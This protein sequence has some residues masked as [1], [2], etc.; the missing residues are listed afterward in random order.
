VVIKR[1][2]DI[3]SSAL[4][5]LLLSPLLLSLAA[6]IK[7]GSAGSVFYRGQRVG[8]HGRPFRIFKFRSMVV[9]AEAIG[10][11]STGDHDPR[12]TSIG[13]F[14]R[15]GKL[16]ELPQ[17]L[18]V[19]LGQM[20]LVGPRPEVQRYVDLYT[21]EERAILEVRPGITD[22]ASIWN[23][24]EGAI[25][26]GS[27][28]PDKAY[29]ELIR[30]T[31]LK[32][33]LFYVRQHSLWIDLKIIAYTLFK[34]FNREF[35][36][37][38]IRQVTVALATPRLAAGKLVHEAEPSFATVTELPGH[39]AT[40]EQLSMIHTRYRLAAELAKDKDVLELACGP[41]IALGYLQTVARRVV[42]GD[43]D[44][45]LVEAASRHYGSRVEVHQIDAQDIPYENRTFDVIL[46]LE[47]IYYLPDAKKFI[48][49][50]QRVLRRNGTIMICSANRERP[51]FNPSP[52]THQYFSAAELQRL[53]L[54]NGFRV[55]LYGAYPLAAAGLKS[56]VLKAMRQVAVKLHL[57]P[58][59]MA[60]KIWL[61]RI[62]F[63][64]LAPVPA[65]IAVDQQQC[66]E[67]VPI[68]AGSPVRGYK[69]IYAVG[70][71][72]A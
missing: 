4:G 41:G 61:K 47:A 17:L 22:W 34:L 6:L 72:A 10:G 3:G 46:L 71:R 42:G 15:K 68:D 28:D 23:S 20:S 43:V 2:L 1:A 7:W 54:E 64:S 57:V 30:P 37:S 24:D 67:L 8:R 19:L 33:Q 65:E 25:L 44:G 51:D 16:D 55:E 60:W 39:G 21:P 38:E 31:K 62:V 32:L 59:T 49:E 48:A 63:G 12:I 70:H 35:L 40:L 26:A 45:Q 18:N 11:S 56:R 58:K 36:P 53:M 69:V 50:A 14:M 5:L 66:A 27:A 9:N 29:K 52:Y 13:R